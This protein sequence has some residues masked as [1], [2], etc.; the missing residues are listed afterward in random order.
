MTLALGVDEGSGPLVVLVHGFP[1]TPVSWHHQVGPLV[2]AG[3]RVVA[4]WLRGYGPSPGSDDPAEYTA[5]LIADDLAE[6][7]SSLGYERAG[8]VGHDW[9]SASVWATAQL[10]PERVAAMAALSVPYTARSRRPPLARFAEVFGDRFFYLLYFCDEPGRAERELG[11]DVRAALLATYATWSG[12]PPAGAVWDLPKGA[13]ILDQLAAPDHPL[14]WLEDRVLDEGVAAFSARGFAGALGYYRA[15]DLTW[16]R[17]P[18]FGASPVT[19]PAM[20]LGGERDG[21]LRFTPTRAMAPPLVTDLRADVRVPAV[22]HWVQQE[23]PAA[24]NAALVEFLTT[25]YPPAG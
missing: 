24:T 8:Y 17:V 23:A 25:A 15:M 12:E 6:V 10:R 22:G 16:A 7:A 9:G 13:S 14:P 19:C 2:S 11:A 20:F 18:A 21:V 3:Y 5:D 1:E 4:P